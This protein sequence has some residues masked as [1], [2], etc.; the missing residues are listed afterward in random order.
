MALATL[1]PEPERPGE[2]TVELVPG[3]LV[4]SGALYATTGWPPRKHVARAMRDIRLRGPNGLVELALDHAP[5]IARLTPVEPLEPGEH[6][7]ERL[8]RYPEGSAWFAVHRIAVPA[9]PPAPAAVSLRAG[10]RPTEVLAEAEGARVVELAEV[11]GPAV[12]PPLLLGFQE[13]GL[14][15]IPFALEGPCSPRPVRGRDIEVE[16]RDPETKEPL[17]APVPVHTGN[18]LPIRWR[19]RSASHRPDRAP[20]RVWPTACG[21]LVPTGRRET[22]ALAEA[23]VFGAFEPPVVTGLSEEGR[24]VDGEVL[25][26]RDPVVF[27]HSRAGRTQV[28]T[29]G[30]AWALWTVVPGEA[31]VATPLPAST[32]R[33]GTN[34]DGSVSLEDAEGWW[35]VS[36]E[37]DLTPLD[38]PPHGRAP[39]RVLGPLGSGEVVRRGWVAVRDAEGE[40]PWLSMEGVNGVELRDDAI[41]LVRA[42]D[43]GVER[44]AYACSGVAPDGAPPEWPW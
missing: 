11:G 4:A 5:G 44:E 38:A 22:H 36:P 43:E 39:T 13:R 6:V 40:T 9:T 12:A 27:A 17:T 7:V 26:T 24:V 19:W 29:H 15:G 10:D 32:R 14:P 34:A 42:T 33:V 31:P 2:A 18:W 30:E 28:F 21:T 25:P 37:G 23:V 1:C 3:T 16:L 35:S 41:W 8:V 20:T